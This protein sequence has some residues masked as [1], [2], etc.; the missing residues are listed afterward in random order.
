MCTN[1][2]QLE[3]PRQPRVL[4]YGGGADSFAVLLRAIE[5]GEL[6]DAVVFVDVSNGSPTVDPTDPGE[7]PGTYKH[8]REIVIPLCE[9]HG[10]RFEWIDSER[11]RRRGSPRNDA[12]RR[13]RWRCPRTTATLASRVEAGG[14]PLNDA[15]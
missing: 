3:L 7:W 12:L 13:R 10:I 4:S 15:G 8:I 2:Q 1:T 6:P 14:P 5:L 9:A 11:S